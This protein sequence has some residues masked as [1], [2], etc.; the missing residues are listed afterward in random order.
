MAA[1][2]AMMFLLVAYIVSVHICMMTM[3]LPPSSRS[4]P[5]TKNAMDLG[6]VSEEP[7]LPTQEEAAV[8][9]PQYRMHLTSEEE[10]A[11]HNQ[12]LAVTEQEGTASPNTPV[13]EATKRI[14]SLLEQRARLQQGATELMTH[15]SEQLESLIDL[16]AVVPKEDNNVPPSNPHNVDTQ[17][18]SAL[19][20]MKRFADPLAT[21][22]EELMQPFLDAMMDLEHL[23]E[24]TTVDWN[25]LQLLPN[26][27]DDESTQEVGEKTIGEE[28]QC[29]L[30]LTVE[31]PSSSTSL[32]S[33]EEAANNANNKDAWTDDVARESNLIGFIS[34]MGHI[35]K[36]RP[37]LPSKFALE[38]QQRMEAWVQE[39]YEILSSR[40]RNDSETNDTPETSD[41]QNKVCLD[42]NDVMYLT[43]ETLGMTKEDPNLIREKLVSMVR[44]LMDEEEDDDDKVVVDIPLLD[45]ILD[46]TSVQNAQTTNATTTM[47]TPSVGAW[48]DRAWMHRGV[49]FVVD[50]VTEQLGG[51]NDVLDQFMDS[52]VAD[53]NNQ[54]DKTSSLGKMVMTKLLT[55]L[56]TMDIPPPVQEHV[57]AAGI[58]LPKRFQ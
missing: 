11:I 18:L 35:L 14:Q 46:S 12:V 30:I 38:F 29:N 39:N 1:G 33:K 36:H 24:M 55:R 49:V 47:M 25:H 9:P 17:K 58:L 13:Q 23:M 37:A 40:K 15:V 6:V 10:E 34:D 20:Q 5:V 16:S 43:T 45:S 8:D 42:T 22:E 50:F 4:V 32:G 31:S 57:K 2:K 56:G 28:G 21:T 26:E 7:L 19:L 53:D 44:E 41:D 52:L 51:Y 27:K 3:T 48:L 54:D